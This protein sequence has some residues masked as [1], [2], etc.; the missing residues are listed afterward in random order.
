MGVRATHI[1]ANASAASAEEFPGARL[2]STTDLLR[3]IHLMIT[4][5]PLN[6]NEQCVKS[7]AAHEHICCTAT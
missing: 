7:S 4:L 3:I 5:G 2:R 6:T 1:Q